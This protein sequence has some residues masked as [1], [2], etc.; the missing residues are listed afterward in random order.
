MF[1]SI[2]KG[3]TAL[4]ILLFVTGIVF[5]ILISSSQLSVKMILILLAFSVLITLRFFIWLFDLD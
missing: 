3:M 2:V 5:P 1:K 4:V